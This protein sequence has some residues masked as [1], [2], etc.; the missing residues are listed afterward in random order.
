M[1]ALKSIDKSSARCSTSKK[2]AQLWQTLQRP[3]S[4]ITYSCSCCSSYKILCERARKTRW[5][6]SLKLGHF[7]GLSPIPSAPI[8]STLWRIPKAFKF[9]REARE[10]GAAGPY[11]FPGDAGQ[12]SPP[13]GLAAA[14]GHLGGHHGAG[15]PPPLKHRDLFLGPSDQLGPEMLPP[16]GALKWT[17]STCLCSLEV[18]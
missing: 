14:A 3:S 4:F 18:F 12:G 7:A 11:L 16:S 1:R 17:G 15:P 10:R 8:P 13:M 9:S 2:L 5:F 6:P